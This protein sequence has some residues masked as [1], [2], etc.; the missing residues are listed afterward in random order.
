MAQLKLRGIHE[1]LDGETSK[2]RLTKLYPFYPHLYFYHCLSAYS[3]FP[4]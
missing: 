3:I 1:P 4:K 2:N